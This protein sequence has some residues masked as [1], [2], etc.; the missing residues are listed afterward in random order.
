LLYSRAYFALDRR[1]GRRLRSYG[2][3]VRLW[4]MIRR[5]MGLGY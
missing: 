2:G 5:A 3:V 1:F 4:K